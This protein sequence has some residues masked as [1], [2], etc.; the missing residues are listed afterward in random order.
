[1][2]HQLFLRK[3]W[4][5]CG[6]FHG[7]SVPKAARQWALAYLPVAAL[8]V[9]CLATALLPLSSVA[10]AQQTASGDTTDGAVRHA[11][12]VRWI[13]PHLPDSDPQSPPTNIHRY[14]QTIQRFY[15][16]RLTRYH[17]LDET[18]PLPRFLEQAQ[19]GEDMCL[20]GILKT[21]ERERFLA[22][23]QA[24]G[25]VPLPHVYITRAAAQRLHVASR[26]IS[27]TWLMN[28]PDV[29]AVFQ[30]GRSYGPL[31]AIIAPHLD[32]E[33]FF[34]STLIT[35]TLAEMLALDRVD[36]FIE[37]PLIP[38]SISHGGKTTHFDVLRISELP[39]SIEYHIACTDTARGREVAQEVDRV[40][41]RE[42]G[43]EAY[44]QLFLGKGL[45]LP[46]KTVRILDRLYGE[47]I[48]QK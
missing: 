29:R 35:D 10:R 39:D 19:A 23:S 46:E 5:G 2:K 14:N 34:E 26:D 18:M 40:L 38:D 43:S 41:A 25:R 21:P 4:A 22:Y 3:P 15:Q 31:D 24:V 1:M 33:R 6:A 20:S 7:P 48:S 11:P 17:H 13:Q 27:L 42:K 32:N 9:C 37:Y 12:T 8:F 47:F 45:R 30:R 16:D 28:Q 44:R 36:F